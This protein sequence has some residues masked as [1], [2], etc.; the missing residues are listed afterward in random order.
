MTLSIFI[1]Y[2]YVN[3]TS[4][5]GLLEA[6]KQRDPFLSF[7][8]D[9]SL[10]AVWY[11]ASMWTDLSFVIVHWRNLRHMFKSIKINLY[12]KISIFET[13]INSIDAFSTLLTLTNKPKDGS[14][15]NKTPFHDRVF[16]RW[17]KFWNSW[18]FLTCMFWLK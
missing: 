2:I 10:H 15:P 12:M 8:I 5:F 13:L 14:Q 3:F 9:G 1:F 4:V 6:K 7:F 11:F 17:K 18:W 16:L